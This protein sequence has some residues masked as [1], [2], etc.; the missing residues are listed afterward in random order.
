MS[1]SYHHG[2]LPK[3]LVAAAS[4]IVTESGVATLSVREVARRVGVSPGAPFRHFSSREAL[5]AAVAEQAMERL[6]AAIE[7][8]Q[9]ATDADPLEQIKRIG[10]AYIDWAAENPTHFAIISQ[11]DLVPLEGGARRQNDAIKARMLALLTLARSQGDLRRTADLQ[12]VLLSCRAMVYG[13]SRMLID[14]HFPEWC[15]QGD[16]RVWMQESLDHFI[17]D[18][19]THPGSK[20][21]E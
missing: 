4:A 1:K 18:L 14:G 7:A 15:P 11:R 2:D 6:V 16:P 5:L 20:A 10:L 17:R 9:L 3:A 19:R 13:L 12:T 21:S 8:G